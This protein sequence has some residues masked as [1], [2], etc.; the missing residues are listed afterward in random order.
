MPLSIRAR[1]LAYRFAYRALQVVWFVRRPHKHGIK[2]LITFRGRILLVRHTYGPRAWDLP[3][4]GMKAGESPLDAARRE[5]Q[6]ELGLGEAQWRPG[7][8]LRGTDSF[9]HDC[10]HCFRADLASAEITRDPV[11]LAVA[12]WFAPDALPPD[13]GRHVGTFLVHVLPAT[14]G[15]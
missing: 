12:E 11:E 10:V 3:G 7:G 4:G 2:C 1:R 8:E 5:M 9:R 15:L 14:G 13:L 6:E